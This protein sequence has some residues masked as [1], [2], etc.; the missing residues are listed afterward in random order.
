M[1]SVALL[2]LDYFMKIKFAERLI[3][4]DL[5]SVTDQVES[6]I[7]RVQLLLRGAANVLSVSLDKQSALVFDKKL[8]AQDIIS[9][10]FDA[11]TKFSKVEAAE[12]LAH[13]IIRSDG[14]P[15]YEHLPT[16]FTENDPC[17]VYWATGGLEKSAMV[18]VK[19]GRNAELLYAC[20]KILFVTHSQGEFYYLVTKPLKKATDKLENY[21]QSRTGVFVLFGEK[22]Q[23]IETTK[24][25]T[26]DASM[27]NDMVDLIQSS[28]KKLQSELVQKG[29]HLVQHQAINGGEFQLVYGAS[30]LDL[31]GKIVS[32]SWP[33]YII[34]FGL[35]A[36]VLWGL[37]AL[38][39]RRFVKPAQQMVQ[40]I[41]AEARDDIPSDMPSYWEPWFKTI[42]D[43]FEQNQHLL[44]KS[45][46]H[47]RELENLVAERTEEIRKER[48]KVT[49][50]LLSRSQ[51]FTNM[52]H[53]IRT[54]LNAVLG[55]AQILKNDLR[56]ENM[57]ANVQAILDSGKFL[58]MLL[59]DILDLSKLDAGKFT[60]N[61]SYFAPRKMF[62]EVVSAFA[63]KAEEKGIA[64]NFAY[65]Q[66]MPD[67][68]ELDQTRVRQVLFNL[69]GNA[70]KFTDMGSVQI[71][72][73]AHKSDDDLVSLY[74]TVEDTGVGI[75]KHAQERI[76]SEYVQ[77]E[78]NEQMAGSGLGLSI[79]K[80]LVELMDGE[81]K[82]HSVLGVGTKFTVVLK[83]VASKN[84]L[85]RLDIDLSVSAPKNVSMR[86]ARVLVVDD[87]DINR[88]IVK[89]YLTDFPF[90]FIDAAGGAEA[91]E[92][93]KNYRPDVILLDLRMPEVSGYDVARA[94]KGHEKTKHSAIVVVTTAAS[95]KERE[96]MQDLC[97]A[98]V[99]KPINPDDLVEAL[100]RVLAVQEQQQ[101]T[102]KFEV[103]EQVEP[104]EQSDNV[105]Y[106]G[107]LD[108]FAREGGQKARTLQEL[109]IINEAG[110]FAESLSEVSA[111]YGLIKASALAA[112]LSAS[113]ARFDTEGIQSV[114]EKLQALIAQLEAKTAEEHL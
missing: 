19:G 102:D 113:A 85:D 90:E 98:Y 38:I 112:E 69:V 42:R 2:A 40:Y 81:I 68:L 53:E 62:E 55:F 89:A 17:L 65:D 45:R 56:Q 99:T 97:D 30:H 15:M 94:I 3:H 72:V 22:T 111:K 25:S 47:T 46:E 39:K 51:F 106:A 54:P 63:A 109:P 92:L 27:I 34:V 66:N 84:V 71:S 32:I 82:L 48:D 73:K 18:T 87:V 77:E 23:I 26:D 74:I 100:H 28:D 110:S 4:S 11:L 13:R 29:T 67:E 78:S 5:T 57:K 24:L 52:S 114:I 75:P 108:W 58:L 50:A 93:A 95:G 61:K 20:G 105:D 33:L 6:D 64:L 70:I 59:N 36:S 96:Q 49:K 83:K 16:G 60:L 101:Q 44:E 1:A 7:E 31:I 43:T 86:S 9:M 103:Q 76:F 41:Q 107:F 12:V 8:S 79:T 88:E 10:Q 104:E 21:K 91:I 35:A 37:N 80:R 14:K